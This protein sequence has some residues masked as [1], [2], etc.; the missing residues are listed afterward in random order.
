MRSRYPVVFA[1]TLTLMAGGVDAQ[2]DLDTT[3]IDQ[4]VISKLSAQ[5]GINSKVSVHLDLTQPFQTKS[6]WS[7]LAA[8]QPDEES[9]AENGA[10][11][12]EGAIFLCFVE[13][14]EPDSLLSFER[15]KLTSF[16]ELGHSTSS[17][18]A[19]LCFR[20]PEERSRC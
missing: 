11:E 12:R 8:K 10:G 13:N 18:R 5:F 7:V 20:G 9:S 6:R 4:A 3:A 1:A 14:V 15:R 16:P 19:T 2:T 17:L